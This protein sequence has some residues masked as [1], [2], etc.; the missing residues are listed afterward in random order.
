MHEQKTGPYNSQLSEHSSWS[1]SLCCP[2]RVLPGFCSDAGLN[3]RGWGWNQMF[4]RL[5]NDRNKR[6]FSFEANPLD[7]DWLRLPFLGSDDQETTELTQI[8]SRQQVGTRG[9]WPPA[10]WR[11]TI[12][13]CR[14]ADILLS[15]AEQSR[16]ERS[17][18]RK[19]EKWRMPSK[20]SLTSLTSGTRAWGLSY[21]VLLLWRHI[22]IWSF[23]VSKSYQFLGN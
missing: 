9:G 11:G 7:W 20:M 1:C 8:P 22:V 19:G 3:D 21:N 13:L 12:A 16:M 2:G 6:G 14:K 15:D 10:G 23:K 18:M 4:F 17:R 5:V